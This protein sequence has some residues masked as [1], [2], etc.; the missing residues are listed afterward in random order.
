[1]GLAGDQRL[2]IGRSPSDRPFP[3]APF[4][5]ALFGFFNFFFNVMTMSLAFWK[6]GY[7]TILFFEGCPYS[8]EGEIFHSSWSLEISFF[9]KIFLLKLKFT[10]TFISTVGIF[11][12]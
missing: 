9:S 1:M 2:P 7:T 8:W 11:V 6:N 10:R 4:F 3:A 12:Y 5:C